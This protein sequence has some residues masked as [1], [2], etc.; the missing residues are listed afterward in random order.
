MF[1]KNYFSKIQHWHKIASILKSCSYKINGVRI[2]DKKPK[3]KILF[4]FQKFEI[5]FYF[6]QFWFQRLKSIFILFSFLLNFEN[7]FSFVLWIGLYFLIV[8]IS[9]ITILTPMSVFNTQS[10]DIDST[11]TIEY[12][13]LLRPVQKH[14]QTEIF[15][16]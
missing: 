3:K 12:F 10:L 14:T 1:I 6:V 5:N 16:K 8:R 7:R 4:W 15:G 2:A 13:N 11:R 9:S